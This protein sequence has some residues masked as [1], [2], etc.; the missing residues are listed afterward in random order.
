VPKSYLSRFAGMRTSQLRV[1]DHDLLK[2]LGNLRV[3][4]LALVIEVEQ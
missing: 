4:K 2:A 1:T 3:E